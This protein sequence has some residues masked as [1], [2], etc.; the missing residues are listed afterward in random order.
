MNHVGSLCGQVLLCGKPSSSGYAAVLTVIL[1]TALMKRGRCSTYF[2]VNPTESFLRGQTLLRK[3]TFSDFTFTSFC[4]DLGLEMGALSRVF[5]FK[6]L[7]WWLVFT[8]QDMVKQDCVYWHMRCA[9][10]H[11]SSML[12]QDLFVGAE[13]KI[14]HFSPTSIGKMIGH[15]YIY[16]SRAHYTLKSNRSLSTEWINKT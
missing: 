3:W 11:D 4:W 2:L 7:L 16:V 9:R 15:Y 10:M 14:E 8:A 1:Q 12:S 13:A 5:F 6:L